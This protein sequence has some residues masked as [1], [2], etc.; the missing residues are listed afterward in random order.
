MREYERHLR[1]FR[2]WVDGTPE[3][4]PKE[5][6]KSVNP[7]E[8][9]DITVFDVSSNDIED[10]VDVMVADDYSASSI[11]V[12][13]AALG[14]FYRRAEQFDGDRINVSP[15]GKTFENPMKD[16]SELSDWKEI[17]E[18]RSQKEYTSEDDVPYLEPDQVSELADNVPKPSVRN[19]LLV[20]LAAQTGLRRDELVRLKLSDGT[21]LQDGDPETF[22]PGPPRKIVIREEVAKNDEKRVVGWDGQLDFILKQWIQDY[23]PEVAMAPVSD[24]LFPS[25]RSKHISGQAFNDVVK[26][27]AENAGIQSV[28][29]VNKAGQERCAVTAHVLRHTFAMSCIDEWDIYA[30]SRALGHSS[31]QVTE[32]HYL[33]EGEDIVMRHFRDS[34][35]NF[36]GQS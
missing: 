27:A 15:S 19:E 20:R 35:P 5:S 36:K 16:V 11:S 4:L 21:W 24:Y 12:R 8:Y 26:E 18:E 28:Q 1:Y 33:H 14:E 2:K 3:T 25:N 32:D 17:R 22:A 6:R 30:L 31:V 34:G 23:R 7:T 29:R 10:M 13:W 9:D